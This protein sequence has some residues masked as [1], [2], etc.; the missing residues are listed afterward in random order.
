MTGSFIDDLRDIPGLNDLNTRKPKN[1]GLRITGENADGD[2]DGEDDLTEAKSKERETFPCESCHGTGLYQHPRLHQPKTECFACK[3]R[4][5]YFKSYKDRME[6]RAKRAARKQKVKDDAAAAFATQHPDLW[7]GMI[8]HASWNEFLA[9]L[10]AEIRDGRQN[11]SENAIAAAQRTVDK[12]NARDAE[13]D[14]AKAKRLEGAAVVNA[15]ALKDAFDAAARNG[16]KR[17]ILRY[18]GFQVS[19]APDHGK[20]AGALYVKA[21]PTKELVEF[22]GYEKREGQYLGKIVGGKYIATREAEEMGLVAKVVEAMNDPLTSARA[23][24]ARTGNCSCCGRKLTDKHS[25]ANG[26]GPICADKYGWGV[27]IDQAPAGSSEDVAAAFP[28]VKAQT[29]VTERRTTKYEYAEGMTAKDKQR[30]RAALRR[31]ARA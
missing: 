29:A 5:Y 26:I 7:A 3:G 24:G 13:R 18:D 9:K 4:G 19:R 25:V 10:V 31:Q 12:A 20:N 17:P 14:A 11:I 1:D 22:R 8:K 21:S 16:L 27:V 15:A 2:W 23:Y 6:S 28:Q 30:M